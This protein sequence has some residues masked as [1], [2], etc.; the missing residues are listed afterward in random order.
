MKENIQAISL[1]DLHPF[2][3]NPFRV[4]DNDELKEITESVRDYGVMTPLILRPR[5]EG[6]YE[7]ISGHRR[8]RACEKAG[9]TVVPAFVREMDRDAAVIM[10]VDSNIHRENIKPSEKAFAY[11]MKLEVL[12]HQGKRTDLTSVET[13]QKLSR[14]MV[15][16]DVGE[17]QSKIQRYIRL[18]ELTP[19]VLAMVDEGSMALSPAVELSYLPAEEQTL[20]LHT[21]EAVECT[22]SYYQALRMKRLSQEKKLDGEAISSI[23]NEPKPNQKEQ[24]R[25]KTEKIQGFFPPGY[26][27][28]QMEE[29]IMRLLAEWQRRRDKNR[30]AEH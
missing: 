4:Q 9:I 2:P 16:E 7:I 1:G 27:S 15:A 8:A 20:V 29:I 18:T 28:R 24:I 21:M 3:G 10:L 30:G 13:E 19:Q 11:K 25:L 6:G 22:P 26:T 14:G 5:D 17:S 12:R 23:L